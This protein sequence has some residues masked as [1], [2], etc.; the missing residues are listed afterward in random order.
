MGCGPPLSREGART[1]W[2]AEDPVAIVR[3]VSVLVWAMVGMAFY[4]ARCE[5]PLQGQ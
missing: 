4:G 1:P 2:C 3:R 5:G